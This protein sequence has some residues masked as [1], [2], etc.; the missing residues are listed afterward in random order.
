M[1]R[2]INLHVIDRRLIKKLQSFLTC[3][4]KKLKCSS[5]KHVGHKFL[6]PILYN[7]DEG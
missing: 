2:N 6:T 7:F 3:C 5:I 4:V 1:L